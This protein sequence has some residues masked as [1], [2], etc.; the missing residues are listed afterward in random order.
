MRVAQRMISRNYRRTVNSSLKKQ[1]DTLER[2]ESG[3][4]F[5]RLSDNVAA[6]NRAMHLQEERYQATQQLENTKD[7]IAEMK[8]VDS[9]MDSIHS[10]LQKLQERILMGMSEDYGADARE[11]ISKEVA[12][13]KAFRDRKSV[14]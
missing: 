13:K 1:A 6:G 14:V 9:N 4:K 8:S 12:S 7:L 11:V 2:S 10:V 5:K 3:L